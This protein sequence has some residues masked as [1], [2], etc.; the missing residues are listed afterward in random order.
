MRLRS[1]LIPSLVLASCA[2]APSVAQAATDGPAPTVASL[3]ANAGPY[4]LGKTSYTNGATPGFGAA[5]VYYPKNA[6]SEPRGAVAFAPGF[7]ESS[8]AVS[9][10][11]Q[12][13]A[14]HGFVTIAINVNNTFTDFPY[15]RA[16]QLL[17]SLDFLTTT[18]KEKDLVD[19]AR[20]AVVG[21]SMGGGATLDASRLRPTLKAAVG[22]APWNPGMQYDDVT[23]PQLEIGAQN[24]FIAPVSS[25]ARP[26]YNS[27]PTGTPK[28]FVNL[29]G[30][31]H[32]ATNSP[33]AK[34]GAATIA[35]L[36]LNVDDDARYQPFICDTHTAVL[37]S[38]L[39]GYASSC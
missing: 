26:F 34:V 36:K 12:R 4:E 29:K 23:V 10:L 3:R 9:W 1:R 25:N 16:Q 38:E 30:A 27:L 8:S 14:S 22:L 31:G 15:S 33:T 13:A 24:D 6:G 19:P 21:H 35:W 11:A 37:N 5:T 28:V 17:A 20:L 7:T 2:L 18:S 39:A 32:L